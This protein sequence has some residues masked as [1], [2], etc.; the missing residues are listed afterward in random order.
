MARALGVEGLAGAF[1][2]TMAALFAATAL[3][4]AVHASL[5]FAFW[6]LVVVAVAAAP[7]ALRRSLG[8]SSWSLGVLALGAVA[9]ISLWW[10]SGYDGDAFFHLAREQK[11]L[12]LRLA[13]AALGGRVQGR[14][15]APGLRIPA[16]A[17]GDRAD[18]PAGRR[19]PG[20]GRAARAHGPAAALVR[21]DLRGGRDA[22][23]L[24]LGRRRVG[25][26]AVRAPG[27]GAW[28]RRRVHVARAPGDGLAR[29]AAAG[30]ARA[31]V[32]LR[33]SAV[34][35]A[36]RLDRGRLDGDGS[37]PPEPLGARRGR[38]SRIP[39]RARRARRAA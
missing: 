17:C 31:G 2:W 32:R 23:P 19:R 34:C 25:G 1:A 38:A 37:R 14:R 21:A 6:A 36:A 8:F 33:A 4:F 20:R 26:G 3:M 24:S 39:D 35:A 13:L 30:A 5:W 9:G 28:S 18:R 27:P 12:A 22:L 16:L 15:A 7:F 10:V 11:L 29:A